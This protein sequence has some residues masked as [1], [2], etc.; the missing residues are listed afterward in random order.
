LKENNKNVNCNNKTINFKVVARLNMI[1]FAEPYYFPIVIIIVFFLGIPLAILNVYEERFEI[2][3]SEEVSTGHYEYVPN[4][5]RFYRKH[6]I[7]AFGKICKCTEYEYDFFISYKSLPDKVHAET[8]AKYLRRYNDVAFIDRNLDNE[9][10]IYKKGQGAGLYT[11][12][13]QPISKTSIVVLIFSENTFSSFWVCLEIVNAMNKADLVLVLNRSVEDASI[14]TQLMNR[15]LN[16]ISLT[17]PTYIKDIPPCP[18]YYNSYDLSVNHDKIS[19][20]LSS[21]AAERVKARKFYYDV[22]SIVTQN[23]IFSTSFLLGYFYKLQ[24]SKTFFSVFLLSVSLIVAFIYPCRAK[25]PI[26]SIE[27]NGFTRV[28]KGWNIDFIRLERIFYEPIYLVI[29]LWVYKLP[30]YLALP[31]LAIAGVFVS[32]RIIHRQLQH[33]AIAKI[34]VNMRNNKKI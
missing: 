33:V 25:Y 29:F 9:P 16:K 13:E 30:A 19:R 31:I 8:L 2:S 21:I 4:V 3:R 14:I 11:Y 34:N 10:L 24:V 6:L 22:L 12:L 17:A 27:T 1:D 7:E 28:H 26:P 15:F 23:V 5:F 18:M 20:E 32:P